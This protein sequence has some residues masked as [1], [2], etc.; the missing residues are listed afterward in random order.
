MLYFLSRKEGRLSLTLGS[1]AMWGLALACKPTALCLPGAYLGWNIVQR[2][3]LHRHETQLVTWRDAWGVLMGLV[4]FAAIFTKFWHHHGPFFSEFHID[5]VFADWTYELGISLMRYGALWLPLVILSAVAAYQWR[6]PW[7][8]PLVITVAVGAVALAIVPA[9]FENY[10]RY[11][12]RVPWLADYVSKDTG[13]GN[14]WLP[15]GY[16]GVLLFQLPP[17]VVVFLLLG[18]AASFSK[19]WA[20]RWRALTVPEEFTLFLLVVIAVWIMTLSVSSRSY[21]RYLVPVL[22]LVYVFVS[23]GLLLLVSLCVSARQEGRLG[24]ISACC[25]CGFIFWNTHPNYLNYFNV[26]FG[27]VARAEDIHYPLFYEGHEQA[28]RYLDDLIGAEAKPMRVAVVGEYSVIKKAYAR[29]APN[30]AHV[31]EF[32]NPQWAQ[33]ADYIVVTEPLFPV[34]AYR[35][36][37]TLQG[38]E[39]LFVH[40]RDGVRFAGLYRAIDISS[41]DS[42][43]FPL[44]GLKRDTGGTSLEDLSLGYTER[45]VLYAMPDR[46]QPGKLF[47]GGLLRL[48]A[49]DF[50]VGI[51][52]AA[53]QSSR[54]DDEKDPPVLTISLGPD[55]SRTI[56]RSELPSTITPIRFSCHISTPGKVEVSGEWFGLVPVVVGTLELGELEEEV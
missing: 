43:E 30:R 27:G 26:F 52:V 10:V 38:T 13:T 39:Q 40:S 19:F 56:K 50:S 46:H 21:V 55:C 11:F 48:S 25:I 28:L 3:L 17:V 18:I 44:Y 15:G 51:S 20:S 9:V 2:F 4:V 45:P 34:S 23:I 1:G 36:G 16:I 5:S 47:K 42:L 8:T 35:F 49:G 7:G 41:T 22:P 31:V 32:I 37:Q 54:P 33:S 6:N 53:I 29:V 24:G 12:I 14:P